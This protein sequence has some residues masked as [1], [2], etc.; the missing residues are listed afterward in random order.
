MP[1]AT[2]RSTASSRASRAD[3]GARVHVGTSGWAY[4]S[5]RGP[6]YPAGVRPAELLHFYGSR[7]DTVEVN[8][9]FRT[10]PDADAVAAW[11]AAVPRGFR[12]ALKAP[13]TIT[14]YRRLQNVAEP[15]AAFLDVARRLGTRRGPLLVQLH[16]TMR[17]D[18][19]RL[20]AF[21]ERVPRGFA[22]ALE[23]RHPSWLDDATYTLLRRR[24]VALCIADGEGLDVPLVA[25]APFGYV[26]L[27]RDD[28]AAAALRRWATALRGVRGWRDVWVYL[29]HDDAG[30]APARAQAL[31]DALGGARPA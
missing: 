22:I 27:R 15:L 4:A 6:F 28:Y 19:E 18:L 5:W 17:R 24:R 11:C 8:Q 21:L 23:V 10:L 3:A 26:R 9:T 30:R 1:S 20:D 29:R 14:H 25:T 7:F 31:L 2:S 12:F 16:P 13:A